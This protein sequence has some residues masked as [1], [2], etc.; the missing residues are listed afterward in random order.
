MVH[1]PVSTRNMIGSVTFSTMIKIMLLTRVTFDLNGDIVK[2][3]TQLTERNAHVVSHMA[4]FFR[5]F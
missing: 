2:A 5:K 4:L 1:S 3:D